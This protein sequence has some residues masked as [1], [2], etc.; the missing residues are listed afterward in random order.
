MVVVNN[1]WARGPMHGVKI[2][3]N[4][5]KITIFFRE[6]EAYTTDVREMTF[7][8]RT[9]DRLFTHVSGFYVCQDLRQP[10]SMEIK[11]FIDITDRNC[12]MFDSVGDS[13]SLDDINS[14]L[15]TLQATDSFMK[16]NTKKF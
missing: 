7:M 11:L 1:F 5:T 10:S 2:E 16:L 12:N 4:L 8:K 6:V 15:D 3:I 9:R 13:I 14:G